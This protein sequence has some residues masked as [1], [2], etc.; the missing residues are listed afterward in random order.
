[1]HFKKVKICCNEEKIEKCINNER[2][3][4]KISIMKVTFEAL[5]L[6]S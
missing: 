4:I 3:Y 2:K 5:G 1:M 6:R